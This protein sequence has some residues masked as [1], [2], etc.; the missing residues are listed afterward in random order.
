[1]EK[2]EYTF[3]E[4][5]ECNGHLRA[6]VRHVHLQLP[7]T[8]KEKLHVTEQIKLLGVY[9]DENLNFAGTWPRFFRGGGGG[10]IQKGDGPN[11]ARGAIL[12]GENCIVRDCIKNMYIFQIF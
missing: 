4:Q 8:I 1:M 11:E 7:L 6:R 9:T 12:Q 10:A 5:P 3:L 2:T